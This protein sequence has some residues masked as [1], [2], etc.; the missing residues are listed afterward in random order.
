MINFFVHFPRGIRG[1]EKEKGRVIRYLPFRKFFGN[2]FDL[3]SK[4]LS[5]WAGPKNV[6]DGSPAFQTSPA[7]VRSLGEDFMQSH[8]G[9]I[10]PGENFKVG[11]LYLCTDGRFIR[12]PEDVLS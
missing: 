2:A 1:M 12:K 5:F 10:P 3:L 7:Q 4:V 11:F 6:N 8:R 9:S